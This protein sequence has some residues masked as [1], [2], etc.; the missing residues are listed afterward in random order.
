MLRTKIIK[1]RYIVIFVFLKLFFLHM[2]CERHYLRIYKF[3][4]ETI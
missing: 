3:F 1:E 2:F 4:T